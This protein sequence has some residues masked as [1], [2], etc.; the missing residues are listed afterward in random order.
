MPS[1]ANSYAFL[2]DLDEH[3]LTEF[4][5]VARTMH[6]TCELDEWKHCAQCVVLSLGD[7]DS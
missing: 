2:A 7:G 1:S 5:Q 3:A 4:Q 6:V